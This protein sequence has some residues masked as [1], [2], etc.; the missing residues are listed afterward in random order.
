MLAGFQR[1]LL[2]NVRRLASYDSNIKVAPGL[3]ALQKIKAFFIV[4][5]IGVFKE[6]VSIPGVSLRYLHKGSIERVA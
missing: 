5:G 6:A 1:K 3:E 4:K 2:E